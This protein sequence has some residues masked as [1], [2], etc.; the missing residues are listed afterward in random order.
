[1]T[2]PNSNPYPCGGATVNCAGNSV[3]L[4]LTARFSGANTCGFSDTLLTWD[5][6]VQYWASVTNLGGCSAAG[7]LSLRCTGSTWV[8]TIQRAHAGC[9]MM[10]SLTSSAS[11]PFQVVFSVTRVGGIGICPCCPVGTAFT[12]TITPS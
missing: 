12:V 11:D 2:A 4:A 8:L 9:G 6:S 3:P 1:M 5:S 7:Y 10:N